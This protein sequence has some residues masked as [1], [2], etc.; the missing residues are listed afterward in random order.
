MKRRETSE[1]ER[2]ARDEGMSEERRDE[3]MNKRRVYERAIL[4]REGQDG[5]LQSSHGRNT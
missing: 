1:G 2:D 4:I 3:F 5:T